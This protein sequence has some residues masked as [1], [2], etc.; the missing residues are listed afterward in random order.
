MD[1]GEVST[2]R[3]RKSV[4]SEIKAELTNNIDKLERLICKQNS[5]AEMEENVKELKE[6]EN[7]EEKEKFW[8]TLQQTIEDYNGNLI[9][10]GDFNAR[11]GK[12]TKAMQ[13]KQ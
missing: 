1:R 8:E 3:A 6:D 2:T 7:N 13:E 12:Q 11:M 10:M 9:L 4:I 5:N